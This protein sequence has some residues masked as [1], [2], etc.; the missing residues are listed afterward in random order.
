M[1]RLF[2]YTLEITTLPMKHIYLLKKCGWGDFDVRQDRIL[3]PIQLSTTQKLPV[4]DLDYLK[5]LRKMTV[6]GLR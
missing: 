2:K 1:E 3:P 6:I 5:N 4:E